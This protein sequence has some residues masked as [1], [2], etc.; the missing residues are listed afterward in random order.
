[1]L[2][3][4]IVHPH[5]E[6]CNVAWQPKWK[7]ERVELEAIKHRATKLI[8][9]LKEL[10]YPDRLKALSLPSLYYRK[11]RGDMIECFKYTSG[12][13]N[14]STDLIPLDSQVINPIAQ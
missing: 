2:Y 1:M 4:A 9:T 13:Y 11:V 12:I 7:K 5:L 3:K 8:L 6:Y 14:V 10:A